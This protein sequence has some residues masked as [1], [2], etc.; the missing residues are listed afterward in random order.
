MSSLNMGGE[1]V[2]VAHFLFDV[3][4]IYD[5]EIEKNIL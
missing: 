4:V 2:I 5:C 3:S 1:G